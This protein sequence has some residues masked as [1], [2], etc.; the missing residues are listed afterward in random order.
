MIYHRLHKQKQ[1][2]HQTILNQFTLT[3]LTI[4]GIAS[5]ICYSRELSRLTCRA[6]FPRRDL[7]QETR[8]W[9]WRGWGSRRADFKEVRGATAQLSPSIHCFLVRQ[10]V[11]PF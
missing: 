4:R 6:T 9:A 5:F 1:S 7:L 8:L 2:S 10:D 3:I 11:S